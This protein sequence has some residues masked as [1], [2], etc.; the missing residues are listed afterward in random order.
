MTAATADTGLTA[1]FEHPFMQNAFIAGTG[2]AMAAGLVGYFL[3]LRAQVFT[4]D[5]LSH[6]AFTGALA[7]LATGIDARVGLFAA[8]VAV[9]CALGA[10][11]ALGPRGHADDVVIGSVF[12]WVLGL[13]V[14]FL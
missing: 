14:L 13:G 5:A 8:T 1:M 11:G 9:G 10:L 2:I 3:V 4:A 6:V 12:A 7:A